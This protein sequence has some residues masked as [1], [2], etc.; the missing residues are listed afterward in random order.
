MYGQNIRIGGPLTPMVKRIMI[1]NGAVFLVIKFAGLF[2]PG[3]PAAVIEN[4]GLSHE[5]LAHFKI[6]QPFTY[7]FLHTEFFHVFMNLFGL[8]MFS[9]D[10]EQLWGGRRF[11]RYYLASGVGA[12]LC[13]AVMNFILYD[14]YGI[15]PSTLGASGAL[16]AV[17]LAYGLTWPN[18]E[19]LFWFVLPV[20]MKYLLI[21]F[22]L[23]EFFGSLNMAS[24]AR[25]N[26]SHI[27]HLG[28]ILAG[29][30]LFTAEKRSAASAPRPGVQRGFF[31]ELFRKRKLEKKKR[32]IERRTEAK[33]IIDTLL[34][35]IA[36]EGMSS[37]T[38]AEKKKLDWAR[39]H[40]Y[41]NGEDTMH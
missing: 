28:G 36:R 15:S 37:L 6:W 40:Y 39:R 27:G 30:I 20:K 21:F 22:G 41:P 13:I 11:L 16:Y 25:G 24:G 9:G 14:R 2:V 38:A 19:V 10:L 7:M 29:F 34:E 17:L 35:K 12:G 33:K 3:L 31:D 23:V 1:V 4:F 32:D 8:W 26:I 18:R 5:G